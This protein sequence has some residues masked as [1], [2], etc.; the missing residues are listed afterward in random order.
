[1]LQRLAWHCCRTFISDPCQTSFILCIS[2]VKHDH[3]W[4]F[5]VW[6][7]PVLLSADVSGGILAP[8][9]VFSPQSWALWPACHFLSRGA[10][11]R[12]NLRAGSANKQRTASSKSNQWYRNTTH[13]ALRTL[14]VHLQVKIVFF[15]QACGSE[16]L[17]LIQR[18]IQKEVKH[19]LRCDDKTGRPSCFVSIVW[20]QHDLICVWRAGRSFLVHAPTKLWLWFC[21]YASKDL[22][23][24]WSCTVCAQHTPECLPT[25]LFVSPRSGH[26]APGGRARGWNLQGTH[27]PAQLC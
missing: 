13:R 12:G 14:M 8:A 17:I 10:A 25:A 7:V 4:V 27:Q 18:N 11:G 22:T 26:E 5:S 16:Q 20:M 3:I 6:F 1:M 19:S 23:G 15:S 2:G 24:N 9:A 21:R